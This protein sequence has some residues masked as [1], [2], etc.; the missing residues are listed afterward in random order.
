MQDT[1]H[2][3]VC[4]PK[5]ALLFLNQLVPEIKEFTKLLQK[6]HVKDNML[7]HLQTMCQATIM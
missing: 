7:S 1:S 6:K 3:T 2:N 4:N 5:S